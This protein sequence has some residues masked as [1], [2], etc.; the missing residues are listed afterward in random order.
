MYCCIFK[1]LCRE[2]RYFLSPRN[3]CSANRNN[4]ATTSRP[5]PSRKLYERHA[6]PVSITSKPICLRLKSAVITSGG[7]CRCE[8]VP[9]STISGEREI[10]EARSCF[11]KQEES[12]VVQFSIIVLAETIKLLR[13]FILAMLINSFVYASILFFPAKF[14]SSSIFILN[15]L[16]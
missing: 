5:S 4:A 9:S 3:Q 7:K 14:M 2:Y 13:Y 15:N 10:I 16:Q 11:V 12:F 1:H 8:P 6:A